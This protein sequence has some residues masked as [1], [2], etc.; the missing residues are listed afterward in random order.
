VLSAQSRRRPVTLSLTAPAPQ[1][2]PGEAAITDLLLLVRSPHPLSINRNQAFTL[3]PSGAHSRTPSFLSGG[4][5]RDRR[6]RIGKR[7]GGALSPSQLHFSEEDF[8]DDTPRVGM[9]V[10]AS[11]MQESDREKDRE[12]L[13]SL[14]CALSYHSP[15][16]LNVRIGKAPTMLI[17]VESGQAWVVGGWVNAISALMTACTRQLTKRKRRL[18]W[19]KPRYVGANIC[20]QYPEL[21][22]FQADLEN[23]MATMHPVPSPSEPK[24]RPQ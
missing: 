6:G 5:P 15:P 9:S 16:R 7:H 10:A 3:K 20:P 12:L 22:H 4:K 14:R 1:P 24:R 21:R 23:F 11:Y 13:E 8:G 19:I 18:I 17:P 2:T